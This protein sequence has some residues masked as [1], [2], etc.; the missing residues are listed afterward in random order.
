[1]RPRIAHAN[2]LAQTYVLDGNRA[3][4]RE[5]LEPLLAG[6]DTKSKLP[7]PAL[8][9]SILMLATSYQED[10]NNEACVATLDKWRPALEASSPIVAKYNARRLRG[11]AL[12]GLERFD[13]AEQ[14]A[15]AALEYAVE[16][17]GAAELDTVELRLLHGRVLSRMGRLAPAREELERGIPELEK[18][19]PQSDLSDDRLALAQVMHE[20]GDD[21]AAR[22]LAERALADVT[23]R[24]AK[25]GSIAYARAVMASTITRTDPARARELLDAAIAAWTAAPKDWKTELAAARAARTKLGK[26]RRQ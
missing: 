15:R 16:N 3:R 25:A 18:L 10:D 23:Q 11:Y 14:D 7:H 21:T 13:E 4:S 20:L 17:F 9:V 26:P 19:D 8:A 24:G 1:M 5:I 12:E 2:L 6:L 22:P